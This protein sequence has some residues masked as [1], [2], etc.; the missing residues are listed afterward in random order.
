MNAGFVAAVLLLPELF[1]ATANAQCPLIRD[2]D[3]TRLIDYVQKKYAT[4]AGM[5]LEITGISPVAAT[6]YRKFEFGAT[7]SNSRFHLE[8]YASPDLRFLTRELLDSTVDPAIEERRKADALAAGLTRA[9][10]PARGK[11]DA[12]VTITVFS[13]FQCPYCSRLAETVREVWPEIAGKARLVFH[14]LPLPMHPWARPAAEASLC[15]KEQGEEFFWTLHDFMFEH[16]K[17]ITPDALLPKLAAV[18]KGF[19]HFDQAQ[20]ASC[21]AEGKMAAK[22]DEDVAFAQRNGINATPTVFINGQRTKIVASDQLLTLVLQLS[23]APKRTAV[24]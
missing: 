19:P 20:F 12:S 6:C 18:A 1:A 2:A 9:G 22:V 7:E 21:L 8:L 5:R 15:A 11:S 13:D 16:Q 24:N 23:A 4:P 17:E 3:R 10:L 14:T